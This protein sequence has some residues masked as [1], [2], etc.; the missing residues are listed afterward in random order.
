[1]RESPAVEGEWQIGRGTPRGGQGDGAR[2]LS[3]LLPALL[4]YCQLFGSVY[5]I[6]RSGGP[7]GSKWEGEVGWFEGFA[8][9]FWPRDRFNCSAL[10]GAYGLLRR[11]LLS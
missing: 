1:M 7:S 8:S 2:H 11:K 9:G 5:D 10:L 4:S 6:S 3:A